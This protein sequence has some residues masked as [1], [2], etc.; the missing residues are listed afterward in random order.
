MAIKA[1]RG[2]TLELQ[3][4]FNPFSDRPMDYLVI[5]LVMQSGIILCGIGV[6]ATYLIFFFAPI[7][8][9][10]GADYRSALKTAKDMTFANWGEVFVLWIIFALINICGALACGIGLLITVPITHIA[11][12]NA[13]EQLRAS[14]SSSLVENNP[15]TD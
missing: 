11:M 6:I 15:S 14:T 7:A 4:A 2:E 9:V 3:D 8:V 12:V 1:N 13:F 10:Q 5:G